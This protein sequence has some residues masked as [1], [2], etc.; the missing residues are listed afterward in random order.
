MHTKQIIIGGLLVLAGFALGYALGFQ[1][2]RNAGIRI[3][4]NQQ[5]SAENGK[6][7]QGVLDPDN[8][9]FQFS[10]QYGY[11]GKLNLPGY[12]SISSR[13]AS[14]NGCEEEFE[15][16]SFVFTDDNLILRQFTGDFAGNSY[17]GSDRIGLGCFVREQNKIIYENYSDEDEFSGE[18][19]GNAMQKLLLSNRTRQIQMQMTK[20][21]YTS[22]Q[23]APN[24]YSHFRD[25]H[26]F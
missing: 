8:T 17:I 22:G 10:E 23:G 13:C 1:Q 9:S 20:P 18:I 5:A 26:L 16:A 11:F 21:I 7:S 19:S 3:N 12:L 4:Q 25:F 6:N 14:V 24:C 2:G 15:Y